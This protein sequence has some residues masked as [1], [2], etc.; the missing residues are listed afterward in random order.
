MFI[1]KDNIIANGRIISMSI[2]TYD[3]IRDRT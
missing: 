1:D 3:G 2:Y